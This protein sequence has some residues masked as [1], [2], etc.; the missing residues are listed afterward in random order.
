MRMT[1]VPQRVRGI[2]VEDEDTCTRYGGVLFIYSLFAW[3]LSRS[4]RDVKTS[5]RPLSNPEAARC[6]SPYPPPWSRY[7]KK[8]VPRT[9]SP[10]AVLP[11]SST[12]AKSSSPDSYAVSQ[13]CAFSFRSLSSPSDISLWESSS[14]VS[15]IRRPTS[16]V[17]RKSG[18]A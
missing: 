8:S 18:I 4:W 15:D 17:A 6:G 11:A 14:A 13:S 16:V 9:S 7:L 12:P 10:P 2:M 1:T 3:A 5:S